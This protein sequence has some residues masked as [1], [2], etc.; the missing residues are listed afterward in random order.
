MPLPYSPR[1]ARNGHDALDGRSAGPPRCELPARA[2]NCD[3]GSSRALSTIVHASGCE[4]LLLY[5]L[6]YRT[7][8]CLPSQLDRTLTDFVLNWCWFLR[9]E[10]RANLTLL[11]ADVSG[12]RRLNSI[13]F[14][15]HV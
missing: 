8:A 13:L 15:L 3:L 2:T 11:E 5:A 12:G 4:P 1:R 14:E 6:L 10:G 9:P 7:D